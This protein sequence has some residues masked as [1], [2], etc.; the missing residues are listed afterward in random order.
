MRVDLIK[1][2]PGFESVWDNVE[3]LSSS[4]DTI[5]VDVSLPPMLEVGDYVCLPGES[6]VPQVPLD[7]LT[8]LEHSVVAQLLRANG[9][10][11]A[12]AAAEAA[13][14]ATLTSAASDFAPRADEATTVV[15]N[16]W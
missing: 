7:Y 8:A 3:V 16:D 13:L 14:Q 15:Q 12:A 2:S 9:D 6:P 11:D 10:M 1:G 4:A 5:N